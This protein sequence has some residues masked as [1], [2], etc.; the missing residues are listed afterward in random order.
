M[1]SPKLSSVCME[2][3]FTKEGKTILYKSI[4]DFFTQWA[5][6]SIAKKIVA[7]L[8]MVVVRPFTRPRSN[9]PSLATL[10][11]DKQWWESLGDSILQSIISGDMSVVKQYAD[12]ISTHAPLA[13]GKVANDIW[14]YPA[15]VVTLLACIPSLVNCGIRGA[16]EIMQPLNQ[17]APDLLADVINSLLKEIDTESLGCTANQLAELVRKIDTGDE[18]LRESAATPLENTI[19][20]MVATVVSGIGERDGNKFFNNVLSLKNK[21]NN[22]ICDALSQNPDSLHAVIHYALLNAL[23]KVARAR[24]LLQGYTV[25]DGVD[26]PVEEIA[27][28]VNDLLRLCV[29][30]HSNN[31]PLFDSLLNRFAH[32]LDAS[33]FEEF[34]N[35]AGK[36]SFVALQPV[37]VH[38]FPFVLNCWATL[39]QEE[40]DAMQHA[41]KAFAKALLKDVEV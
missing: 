36:D 35:C 32:S 18:L 3:L 40:S 30:L 34:V 28:F 10:L 27:Y 11:N 33:A 37:L 22:S 26:L 7:K 6:G 14:M 39:L 2:L 9:D 8:V 23:Q 41:R 15:K 20:R 24:K 38:V 5:K 16:N 17:Q 19:T 4:S 31:K 29:L 25:Q 12:A 21:L 1:N 13:L